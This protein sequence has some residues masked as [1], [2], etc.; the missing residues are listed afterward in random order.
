M[1]AGRLTGAEGA[2]GAAAGPG[3]AAGRDAGVSGCTRGA[4]A[5]VGK[6]GAPLL[7]PLL[8]APLLLD[9]PG[10]I[11]R[12]AMTPG[13]MGLSVAATGPGMDWATGTCTLVSFWMPEPRP[14]KS[15]SKTPSHCNTGY[16]HKKNTSQFTTPNS[17]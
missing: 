11:E 17:Q 8:L 16:T 7:E 13:L 6:T 3:A 2:A 1:D 4:A 10:P 12:A 9:E 15:C 5:G 14:R